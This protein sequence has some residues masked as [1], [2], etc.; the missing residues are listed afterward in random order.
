MANEGL[1]ELYIHEALRAGAF[2]CRC[3]C[4]AATAFARLRLF[5][6][7]NSLGMVEIVQNGYMQ[8][9]CMQDEC[10]KEHQ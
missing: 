3:I 9:E 1:R 2:A 6:W 5:W 10:M 4:R 8:D 7:R